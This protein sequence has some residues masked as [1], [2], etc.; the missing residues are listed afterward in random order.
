MGLAQDLAAGIERGAPR[1][2]GVRTLLL[3]DGLTDDEIEAVRDALENR[4][5]TSVW[6]HD[7]LA[8]YGHDLGIATIQRHRRGACSCSKLNAAAG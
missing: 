2:C 6:I 3:D 5:I 4:H 7:K 8:E 1:S